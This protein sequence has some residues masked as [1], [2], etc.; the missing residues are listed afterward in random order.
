[1]QLNKKLEDLRIL[2]RARFEECPK[3]RIMA[4]IGPACFYPEQNVNHV[5]DMVL[6]GMNILRINCAHVRTPKDKERVRKLISTID[7]VVRETQDPIV[8]TVDLAGPKIRVGALQ[9]KKPEGNQAC[10][11]FRSNDVLT[12]TLDPKFG[13]DEG[14][15][16]QK[17]TKISLGTDGTAFAL[18]AVKKGQAVSMDDGCFRLV[19]KKVAGPEIICRALNDW[20]LLPNKGVNFPGCAITASALTEKDHNDLDWLFARKCG[21]ARDAVHYVSLSFVKS[22]ADVELLKNLLNTRYGQKS[23][24]VISKIETAEAVTRNA[25]DYPAFRRILDV[26]DAIM[27]ARGD[28]G[29]EVPFED[30]PEIQRDLIGMTH[31]A[32]KPVIVATQ[33]L[34][35]MVE[36]EFATRA[37][38]TDVTNAILE[39]ADVTMLSAETSKGRNPLAA[40]RMMCTIA[41]RAS[42]RVPVIRE[43]LGGPT[44]V[45]S[46][47]FN[48][49]AH[50]AVE[51]AEKLG[52]KLIV[53]FTHSG[54]TPIA[55]AHYRPSQPIIA[56]TYN[57][58]TVL[59]LSLYR[60]IYPVHINQ[61]P[62]NPADHR[63]ICKRVIEEKLQLT[64]AGDL[65]VVA[66]SMD[67]GAEDERMTNTLYVL[68]H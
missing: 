13:V 56:I 65:S 18:E 49:M 3:T 10:I 14:T 62:R 50:P 30:V 24:R 39:G 55:I 44:F 47:I 2:S 59:R 4:T 32:Q 38:V 37:E 48:A 42:Q 33:M 19:V 68:P 66:M 63:D 40:V 61:V 28:L 5:R 29:A 67:T 11:A 53:A 57:V 26:S 58:D 20:T 27:V 17:H 60:G 54:H 43:P 15:F 25:D 52:A 6:A 45:S 31:E 23:V 8:V 35:F 34:E 51:F 46:K 9:D 16:G 7:E 41:K 12:L 1:M 21:V 64:E 22:P 36:H